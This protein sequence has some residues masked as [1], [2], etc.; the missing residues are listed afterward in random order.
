MKL[1][2][3]QR[4]IK[5]FLNRKR[6]HQKLFMREEHSRAVVTKGPVG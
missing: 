2:S 4:A 1:L 3:R 5:P 6:L